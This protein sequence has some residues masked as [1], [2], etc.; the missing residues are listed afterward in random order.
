MRRLLTL[1]VALVLS[2]GSLARAE[3]KLAGGSCLPMHPGDAWIETWTEIENTGGAELKGTLEVELVYL[4]G[5]GPRASRA[6]AVAP[7][8][9]KRYH[10]LL[11]AGFGNRGDLV[12][13][14]ADISE[15]TVAHIR[16]AGLWPQVALQTCVVLAPA[17]RR[18]SIL[19]A[20]TEKQ[21]GTL[22]L[23]RWEATPDRLP[24]HWQGWTSA[25]LIVASE[26]DWTQMNEEQRRAIREWVW[27]GGRILFLAG[28]DPA[29]LEQPMVQALAPTGNVSEAAVAPALEIY[30][31]EFPERSWSFEK[32]GTPLLL[33]AGGAVHA[34]TAGQGTAVVCAFDANHPTLRK[35][36]ADLAKFSQDLL[37]EIEVARNDFDAY[38]PLRGVYDW[39][40]FGLALGEGLI[41]YPPTEWLVLGL[42]LYIAVVG[43]LNFFV[44]RRRH[45]PAWT[46]I[47][48]PALGILMTVLLWSIGWAMRETR[49]QANRI[50]VIRPVK[51]TTSAV[52]REHLV[53]A[54][55][56]RRTALV[57]SAAGRLAAMT[58]G[59][60]Y[61][62]RNVPYGGAEGEIL[63]WPFEPREPAW[64]YAVGRR[65]IGV[66]LAILETDTIAVTNETDADFT[67]AVYVDSR[68][69][70]HRGLGRIARGQTKRDR[71][72]TSNGNPFTPPYDVEDLQAHL[73]RSLQG[74]CF[75]SK[76]P[77]VLAVIEARQ[78]DVTADGM[79]VEFLHDTT[80]LVI[81][82]EV[83]KP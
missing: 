67:Y 21:L 2:S 49:I 53:V 63:A 52:V 65:E 78:P 6:I 59:R 69:G 70:H 62:P 19:A 38:S 66:A 47:T 41:G 61:A 7:G 48:V 42:L 34:W 82:V 36:G 79:P 35:N 16:E 23:W 71:T 46:A 75:E 33:R 15:D 8:A 73:L 29:W 4:R 3:V 60:T 50:T 72:T 5:K 13:R 12:F 56:R 11:Y 81:P 24:E 22:R 9:K 37:R 68:F 76:E 77:V 26:T 25:G 51:G 27:S 40:D 28:T 58:D 39:N 1:S 83:K 45:S 10:L 44:L 31:T 54:T 55:G 17:D 80:V 74:C 43:P 18:P 32:P 64:F 14:V 57:A 20:L 30:F